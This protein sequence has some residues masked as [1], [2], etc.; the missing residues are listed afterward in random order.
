MKPS[1]ICLFRE[2]LEVIF[3]QSEEKRVKNP[4]SFSALKTIWQHFSTILTKSNE[5]RV[6]QRTDRFGNTWWNAYD[7]ATGRST[8]VTSESEMR[9]WIEERYYQ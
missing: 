1:E 7:P 8:S 2:R 5:L 9:I 4:K 3:S 6:W